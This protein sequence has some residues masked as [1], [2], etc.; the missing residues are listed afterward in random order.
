MIVIVM[1]DDSR[2]YAGLG[3]GMD[4]G[5]GFYACETKP[6]GLVAYQEM[7]VHFLSTK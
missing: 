6:R 2:G 1:T 3:G 4:G 5:G 7:P